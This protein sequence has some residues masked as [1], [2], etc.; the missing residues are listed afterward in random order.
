MDENLRFIESI[1]GEQLSSVEFVQD[2]VQLRFD[3]PTLTAFVWPVVHGAGKAVGVG[4][5]GYR[6]ELCARIG[7]KVLAARLQEAKALIVEFDDGASVTISLR[8]EDSVGPE[9][10]HFCACSNPGDPILE[11]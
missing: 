6:D 11:F 1:V 2:Y 7:S 8:P 10:G 9:A 3:G 4:E 5:P